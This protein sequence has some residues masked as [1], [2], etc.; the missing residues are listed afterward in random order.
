MGQRTGEDGVAHPLPPVSSVRA[1][2][3]ACRNG[4]FDPNCFQWRRRLIVIRDRHG[5][6]VGRTDSVS[7]VR[8]QREHDRFRAF[9]FR[10]IDWLHDEVDRNRAGRNGRRIA[11]RLIIAAVVRR[12]IKGEV[13][14]ER[15][16]CIAGPA[17]RERA[18]IRTGFRRIRVGRH[19]SY[20]GCRHWCN[21]GEGE[22]CRIIQ[23]GGNGALRA[24]GGKFVNVAAALVGHVEIAGAVKSQASRMI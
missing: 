5:G 15:S 18:R 11:E 16:V 4:V 23:A 6:A 14:S 8:R 22:T 10:I 1:D 9:H 19:H 13:N 3:R 12:P 17:D 20:R 24:V 2:R 7:G 21:G